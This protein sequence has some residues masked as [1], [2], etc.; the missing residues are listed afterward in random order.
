MVRGWTHTGEVPVVVVGAGVAGVGRREG[1]AQSCKAGTVQTCVA[2]P[3][4]VGL[5]PGACRGHVC[6]GVLVGPSLAHGSAPP[7]CCSFF[8]LGGPCGAPMGPP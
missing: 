8:G 1:L 6:A 2:V 3:A 4:W 7:A 5:V